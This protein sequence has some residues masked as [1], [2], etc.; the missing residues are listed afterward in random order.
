M[1]L[2]C[3]YIPSR[4]FLIIIK[5]YRHEM[6]NDHRYRSVENISRVE[7]RI[8]SATLCRQTNFPSF[9]FEES[10]R[11]FFKSL[12]TYINMC[13]GFITT[14]HDHTQPYT[15]KHNQTQPNTTISLVPRI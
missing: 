7:R 2:G 1:F 5:E 14:M 15:T 4:E 10:H 13:T 12:E 9:F 11:R 8:P 6:R 3:S